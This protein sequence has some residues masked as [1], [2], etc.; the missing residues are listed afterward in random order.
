MPNTLIFRSLGLIAL[1]AIGGCQR[2]TEPRGHLRADAVVTTG[3]EGCPIALQIGSQRYLPV[4]LANSLAVP[5]VRLRVEGTVHQE[6]TV[7]MIG[8]VLDI[9]S[10][11]L[12]P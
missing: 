10:A 7:C 3:G 2:V 11:A 1:C 5:G 8:P 12:L 4:G 9:T 6:N